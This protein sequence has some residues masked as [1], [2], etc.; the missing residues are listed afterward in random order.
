MKTRALM[1]NG[2]LYKGVQTVKAV[3]ACIINT[4][5]CDYTE[6]GLIP[7]VNGSYSDSCSI[8]LWIPKSC[9]VLSDNVCGC[10]SLFINEW[11]FNNCIKPKINVSSDL[12][13]IDSNNKTVIYL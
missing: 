7:N 9:L 5:M 2:F 6:N 4:W 13:E 12:V 1:I 3:K 8:D 11:G 10:K